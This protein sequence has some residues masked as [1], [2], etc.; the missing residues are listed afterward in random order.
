MAADKYLTPPE[1]DFML[2]TYNPLLEGIKNYADTAIQY[3]F[4]LLF[5]TAL[6]CASFF[7]LLS[8]YVKVKCNTWKLATVSG[9][10]LVC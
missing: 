10:S 3:G 9:D 6:P 1:Q 8:N 4:S 2:M 7:S 5:I